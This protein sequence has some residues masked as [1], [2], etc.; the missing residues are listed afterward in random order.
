MVVSKTDQLVVDA[1]DQSIV[2]EDDGDVDG[3]HRSCTRR[4]W[5]DGG[6]CW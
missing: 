1:V 6:R 3:Y 5:A 4:R 2:G